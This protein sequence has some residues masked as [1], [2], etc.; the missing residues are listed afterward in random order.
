V[1]VEEISRFSRDF[2]GGIQEL[3]DLR[4]LGV[5]VADTKTDLVDIDSMAGQIQAAVNLAQSQAETK[6]LGERSKRGLRGQ[7]EKKYSS[8]GRPAYGLK[9]EP[10]FSDTEVDQDG[11]P[12]RV[13][14]R[15]VQDPATAPIVRR[16]FDRF[17]AGETK[18]GIARRLNEEGIP[19]RDA[20]RVFDGVRASSNR[21]SSRSCGSASRPVWRS[22]PRSTRSATPR[23]LVEVTSSAG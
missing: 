5:R 18:S 17:D 23:T 4:E 16:I 7:P 8:G 22:R 12:K 2:L 9:R 14:V 15:F 21:S 6:R 11:R 3:A 20:G 13:G 10:E 19:T 1:L